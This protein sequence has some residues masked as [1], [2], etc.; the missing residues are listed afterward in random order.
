MTSATRDRLADR[1]QLTERI[2]TGGM[3]VVW[4]ARDERLGRDVAIKLIRPEYAD[5]PTFR[6]RL[7]LEA[8][9]TAAIRSPHV[10]RLHDVCESP[11]PDGGC[12]AFIVME[13]VEGRP[14]S[15]VLN[16]GPLSVALTTSIIQQTA[17]ALAAAHEQGIIHRDIKPANLMV[18]GAGAVTVLDFGIARAADAVALTATDLILGTARYISPEQADGRGATAAS[19]VYSLGVVAFQCLSGAVPFDAASDVAVALA[20][21]REPVPPLPPTVPSALASLVTRMLAKAPADRP[22]A[23][24]VV[25]ALSD[26]GPLPETAPM[27]VVAA[28]AA[29]PGITRP[30]RTRVLTRHDWVRGH[31]FRDSRSAAIRPGVLLPA[32]GLAALLLIVA[33][34]VGGPNGAPPTAASV[35]G[36]PAA[37]DTAHHIAA[38]GPDVRPFRYLGHDWAK[39]RRELHRLGLVPVPH[40]AGHGARQ[41]VVGLAPT[42]HVPRGTKVTV[43]VSRTPAPARHVAAK[44]QAPAGHPQPAPPPPAHVPPGQAKKHGGPGPG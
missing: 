6:Q 39:V 38:S 14:L 1:Y 8:R 37:T 9:A 31:D 27:P 7:R 19:D 5:D 41:T 13:L 11:A 43:E 44:P 25:A 40:F 30:I 28:A 24:E 2:A 18:D 29:D 36:A 16:D 22:R 32:G 15:S 10:V 23:A 4:R 17:S 33:A 42:G 21:L 12:D 26:N 3:G 20:H 35:T 34:I